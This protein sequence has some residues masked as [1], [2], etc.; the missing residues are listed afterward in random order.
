M[1]KVREALTAVITALLDLAMPQACSG[2]SSPGHWLCFSCAS[3][4]RG[5][6]RQVWPSPEPSGL[7]QVFA[8]AG[9]D[10]V[11]RNLVIAHKEHARLE[12]AT[13]LGNAL[14]EAVRAALSAAVARDDPRAGAPVL[15]P[16]P[17]L[18][19]TVRARGQDP[20]LRMA[21]VAGSVASLRRVGA[22]APLCVAPVLRHRR[23]VA[24]QA[25][26]TAT[27]RAANAGSRWWSSTTCSPP[28]PRW[29]R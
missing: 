7:P 20:L 12:L 14:A 4:L 18:R 29:W 19:A 28:G 10:S 16:V 5:A 23:Q 9:Y 22:Q 27:E 11:V 6:G 2:C 24:D 26:L 15:V 17:S 3:A 21:R 25:G 8:S 1:T 13:P